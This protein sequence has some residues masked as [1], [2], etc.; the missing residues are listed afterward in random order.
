MLRRVARSPFCTATSKFWIVERTMS[1][2]DAFESESRVSSR[3]P[4]IATAASAAIT[5][6]SA[7]TQPQLRL[8]PGR[9]GCVSARPESSAAQ[10]VCRSENGSVG[11][12]MI[13]VAG[14]G[15]VSII[16]VVDESIPDGAVYRRSAAS[17][18]AA[19][20]LC[21]T[22]RL[23]RHHFGGVFLDDRRPS[24]VAGGSADSV[25]GVARPLRR[26]LGCRIRP[27][28]PQPVRFPGRALMGSTSLLQSSR[29]DVSG[30]AYMPHGTIGP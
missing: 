8:R 23:H 22:G 19:D 24:S 16:F 28:I 7:T 13:S 14:S 26:R 29:D 4:S 20:P 27:P 11:V 10:P 6:I 2:C 12:E 1:S 25:D 3:V 30:R 17:R 18:P 15:G 9:F 21:R 5:R